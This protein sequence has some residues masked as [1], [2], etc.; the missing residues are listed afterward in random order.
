MGKPYTDEMAVLWRNMAANGMNYAEIARKFYGY[1]RNQVRHVCVGNCKLDL[2]GPVQ[3]LN[4]FKHNPW[5]RGSNHPN[6]TITEEQALAILD[7]WDE[8]R[9]RWRTMGKV[10]AHRFGIA[11]STVYMIRRGES[12][13]HLNHPNQ[14]RKA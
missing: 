7:D 10:W 11:T 4:R 13:R 3:K 2:P 5:L 1:S 9:G 6:A 14:G 8:E 12:W